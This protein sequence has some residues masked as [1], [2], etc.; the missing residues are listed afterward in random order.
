MTSQDLVLLLIKI[1]VGAV[2]VLGTLLG[3]ILRYTWKSATHS[4]QI[5]A[6]LAHG[7]EKFSEHDERLSEHDDIL[8]KHGNRLTKVE[9][10]VGI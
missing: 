6:R 7:E 5:N 8:D 4:A 1:I 9:T 10:H 2:S 3:F